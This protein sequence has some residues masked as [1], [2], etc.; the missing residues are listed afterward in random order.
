MSAKNGICFDI[1]AGR[2]AAVSCFEGTG[3]KNN[4]NNYISQIVSLFAWIPA[5]RHA[6]ST[7]DNGQRHDFPSCLQEVD[8]FLLVGTRRHSYRAIPDGR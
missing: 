4:R 3:G 1:T 2:P 7:V 5:E 6:K 8:S